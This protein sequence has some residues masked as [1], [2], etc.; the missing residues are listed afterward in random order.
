M[1]SNRFNL[2][3]VF[4]IAE[5]IERNGA[6]FYRR[7]A[8]AVADADMKKQLDALAEMELRHERTFAEIRKKAAA[9]IHLGSFDP[10]EEAA[11]FLR[12][13][14]GGCVFRRELDPASLVGADKS[15]PE[16]F[17]IAIGLEKDSIVFY[18]NLKGMIPPKFGQSR[19]DL[20][21]EEEM[22]HVRWLTSA[23]GDWLEN[24]PN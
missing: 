21:I 1:I 15:V 24:N 17:R 19:V 14:A 16:L 4:E 12:A 9:E 20:I 6:E 8:C 2:D 10:N 3:E 18:L 23:L 13:F 22:Q 7:A 5:E 11:G